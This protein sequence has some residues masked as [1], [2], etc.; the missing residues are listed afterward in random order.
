MLARLVEGL[1]QRGRLG[2]TA[3][4]VV[5]DH[6]MAPVSRDR[7]VFLDDAV[8]YDAVDVD[9]GEVVGLWP[10][11]TVDVDALVARVSALEHLEAYRKEDLPDRLHYAASARIPPVVVLADVGWIATSRD[12]YERRTDRPAGGGHGGDNAAEEMHGLFLAMG[13]SFRT[14][15][16]IGPVRVVDVYGV[17]AGALGVDPAPNDGDPEAAARVLR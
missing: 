5:S 3:L 15:A 12:Y 2:T 9:W 4:V 17:L 14:G 8:D 16:E 6:G 13:P 10:D 1:R 11:A 7:V